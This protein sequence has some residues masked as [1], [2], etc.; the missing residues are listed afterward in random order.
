MVDGHDVDDYAGDCSRAVE[1]EVCILLGFSRNALPRNL[2][3]P[4]LFERKANCQVKRHDDCGFHADEDGE[5]D[6]YATEKRLLG[7]EAVV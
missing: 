7:G 1:A 5:S 6:N 3:V 2:F 4:S